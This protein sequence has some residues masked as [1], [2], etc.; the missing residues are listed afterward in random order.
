MKTQINNLT[1]PTNDHCYMQYMSVQYKI[2]RIRR[3]SRLSFRCK[4][5]AMVASDNRKGKLWQA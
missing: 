5:A 4:L 3:N 1:L 2:E